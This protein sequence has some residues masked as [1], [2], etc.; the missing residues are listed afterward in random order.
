VTEAEI[1]RVV[2][3][4]VGILAEYRDMKKLLADVGQRFGSQLLSGWSF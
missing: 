1:D 4:V 2:D 3:A